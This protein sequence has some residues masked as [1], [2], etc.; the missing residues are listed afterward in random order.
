[1]HYPLC[2][3]EVGA[4]SSAARPQPA[5]FRSFWITPMIR[6]LWIVAQ[7]KMVKPTSRSDPSK[8][9]AEVCRPQVTVPS[10]WKVN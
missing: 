8:Y 2:Y 4:Y 5:T 6:P 7:G 1:M 9:P 3:E 10:P